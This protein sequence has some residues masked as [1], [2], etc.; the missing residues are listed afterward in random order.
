MGGGR[1]V[2]CGGGCIERGGGGVEVRNPI[3]VSNPIYSQPAA[4]RWGCL[5]LYRPR[6]KLHRMPSRAKKRVGGWG[7]VVGGAGVTI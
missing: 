7:G 6:P 5:R 3:V 4:N 2:E 1:C